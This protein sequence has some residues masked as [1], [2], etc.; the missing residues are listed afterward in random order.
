MDT[1]ITM[2]YIE[3]TKM[4]SLTKRSF[5]FPFFLAFFFFFLPLGESKQRSG[6]G[7]KDL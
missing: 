4:K 5:K 6:A 3:I 1:S 2:L 7:Q